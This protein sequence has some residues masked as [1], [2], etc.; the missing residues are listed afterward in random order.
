MKLRYLCAVDQET[1]DSLFMQ[2]TD[3]VLAVV[4]TSVADAPPPV[5]SLF[6]EHLLPATGSPMYT[7]KKQ[8]SNSFGFAVLM[9]CAAILIYL[10]RGSEGAFSALFRYGFDRNL[11][12][13]QARIENSQQARSLFIFTVVAILSIAL[14]ITAILHSRLEEK[15]SVSELFLQSFGATLSFILAKRLVVRLLALVFELRQELK[16]YLYNQNVF[17]GLTGVVLLPLTLLLF[18]SPVVPNS[19]VVILGLGVVGLFYLK[20]LQRGVIVALNS[21]HISA[22]HLFYYFCALEILPVSVLFR[23]AQSM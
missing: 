5:E 14:F 11:A 4:D 6:T 2:P 22:L 9:V 18:F 20:G 7:P 8:T 19:I 3:T 12:Q 21:A 13:Q 17:L 16:L 1:T 10:Q 15:S 23:V